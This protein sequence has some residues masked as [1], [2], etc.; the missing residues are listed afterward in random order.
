MVCCYVGCWVYSGEGGECLLLW[1][2]VSMCGLVVVGSD[3]GNGVG[4]FGSIVS[5]DGWVGVVGIFILV[6]MGGILCLW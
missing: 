5:Y 1:G 3:E 2:L 4:C 6:W